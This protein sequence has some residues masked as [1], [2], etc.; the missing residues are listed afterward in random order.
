MQLISLFCFLSSL[1]PLKKSSISV[2]TKFDV[3][4][5]IISIIRPLRG[6]GGGG[7]VNAQHYVFY[8]ESDIA[9]VFPFRPTKLLIT[10]SLEQV[11]VISS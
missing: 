8:F 2:S 10:K 11:P 5:F 1:T 7:V 6:G 9:K 4:S 3:H